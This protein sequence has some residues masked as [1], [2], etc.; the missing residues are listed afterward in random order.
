MPSSK[1]RDAPQMPAAVRDLKLNDRLVLAAAL[2][3]IVVVALGLILESFVGGLG[4]GLRALGGVIFLTGIS[5]FVL[6]DPRRR[7]AV[8]S[9]LR[10]I[11]SRY[12]ARTAHWGWPDRWGVAAVAIGL[13]FV[14]PALVLQIMFGSA[15]GAP[16]ASVG[17]ILFWVGIG[18]L[19]Y[20][21]FY[22]RGVERGRRSPASPS[23]SGKEGS[24]GDR[25]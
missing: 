13:I 12:L 3:G 6:G 16:V 20:G 17:V 23:R 18:L 9:R 24:G 1:R 2:I 4:S 5:T 15:L 25:R 19:I 21:R 10:Q 22:R 14:V 11:S 7:T 8:Q